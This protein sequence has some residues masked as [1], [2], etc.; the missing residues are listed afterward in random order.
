MSFF[1]Y[2]LTAVFV[3]NTVFGGTCDIGFVAYTAKRA[4]R[5]LFA[6]ASIFVFSFLCTVPFI[7]LDRSIATSWSSSMPVR[8]LIVCVLAA[9]W[10][11]VFSK[12]IEKLPKLEE[13]LGGNLKHYA[14][15]SAVIAVPLAFA[16]SESIGLGSV[17]A[18]SLG[19]AV[20]FAGAI[21][22]ITA[23]MKHASSP[24]IPKAFRGTPALLI[25]IGL[26]S[27]LFMC[28]R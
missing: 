12:L 3:Q 21:L 15:S 22:L 26:L 13:L 25:Y 18:S 28:F 4:D 1:A 5:L 27:L 2:I 20:G 6:S 8:G 10:Y 16:Q 17:F 19:V 11:F 9:L 7:P 24:A 23:G 14:L